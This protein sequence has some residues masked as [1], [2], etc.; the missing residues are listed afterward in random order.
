MKENKGLKQRIEQLE[1]ENRE[2]K[3][4]VFDLSYKC[5]ARGVALLGTPGKLTPRPG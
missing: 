2:L 1:R 4:S 5:A 3:K